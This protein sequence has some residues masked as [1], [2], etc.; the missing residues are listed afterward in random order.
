MDKQLTGKPVAL[1]LK[2]FVKSTIEKESLKPTMALIQLGNDPASEFYVENIIKNGAK[3]GCQI[4]LITLPIDTNQSDLA[5]RIIEL[6]EDDNY[7][8]IM[9]Q[10]PLPRHID[11]T[12]INSLVSPNKD[13]DSLNPVNL[14]KI[15]L[16]ADG[17]LPCTP[18]AV[19]LMMQYYGIDPQGKKL[20][21]LGRSAV[22]GKPLANILLWKKPFANATVTI[23]HSKT[24]DI[25]LFTR[26]ADIV[27][28]AIGVPHFVKPDMIRDGAI[29]IDV[30][31]NEVSDGL[32]GTK[33]VGDI[34][35]NGCFDKALAIT[36]VPGG[37]GTVT[38][39]VLMANLV[40]ASLGHKYPNKKID[41]FFD[42]IFNA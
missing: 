8:G 19:W 33:Y 18:F 11:D 1:Q 31:I 26:E 20:V 14:G 37:V 41:G 40:K 27:I 7:H 2:N 29:L 6:N 23:C 34:D 39:A 35:F 5:D 24:K 21:I 38:T 15:I 32:G 22:V 28:S 42:L 12:E 9:I 30:G 13:I 4:D 36:P 16:E 10:K 3:L 17:F 25:E